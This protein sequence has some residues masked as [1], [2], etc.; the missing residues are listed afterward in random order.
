M[1]TELSIIPARYHVFNT[2]LQKPAF[3]PIQI[4]ALTEIFT[5]KAIQVNWFLELVP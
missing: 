4:R 2:D 5:E 3:G 1:V